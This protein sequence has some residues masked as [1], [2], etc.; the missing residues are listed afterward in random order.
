MLTASV[1]YRARAILT[2]NNP[3]VCLTEVSLTVTND[4]YNDVVALP[5]LLMLA[6][7]SR[8]A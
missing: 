3:V 7:Q 2:T 8:G 4:S 5:R 6:Q 1:L